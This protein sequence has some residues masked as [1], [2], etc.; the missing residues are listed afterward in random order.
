MKM[1]YFYAITA[2]ILFKDRHHL[3]LTKKNEI[4]LKYL[5]SINLRD[6]YESEEVPDAKE[7][8]NATNLPRTKIHPILYQS[9]EAI[10]KSLYDKPHNV[11]KQFILLYLY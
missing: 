3:I 1:N 2:L 11:F 10:I 5:K 8:S 6:D 9:Y 7:I 4:I